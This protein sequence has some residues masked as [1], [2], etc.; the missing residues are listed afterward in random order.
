MCVIILQHNHT[1]SLEIQP[2]IQR[3][4]LEIQPGM[5]DKIICASESE[6]ES[7]MSK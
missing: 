1:K 3:K 2:E 5:F 7:Y 6:D 4:S